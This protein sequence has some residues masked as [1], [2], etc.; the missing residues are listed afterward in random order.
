[1]VEDRLRRLLADKAHPLGQP[2]N[3]A[4]VVR[5]SLQPIRQE[6]RHRLLL[7]IAARTA[8]QQRLAGCVQ[9]PQLLDQV[10]FQQL[11]HGM[12]TGYASDLFDLQP[13]YRLFVGNDG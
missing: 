3:P 2:R 10:Q 13:G 6:V 5:S 11:V 12:V 1:M 8:E 9:S 4:D 7:G